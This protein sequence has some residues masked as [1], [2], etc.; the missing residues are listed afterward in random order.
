MKE[1]RETVRS[2][3]DRNN[4]TSTVLF[5]HYGEVARDYSVYGIPVSFLIDREGKVVFRFPG[6]LDWE[7]AKMKGLVRSLIDHSRI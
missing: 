4:Y 2:F 1:D 5:D 6:Y 7:S 3:I